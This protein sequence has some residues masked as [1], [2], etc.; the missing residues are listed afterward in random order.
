MN[1]V[2]PQLENVPAGTPFHGN[3]G[4]GVFVGGRLVAVALGF[5][6]LG[7]D[8]LVGGTRVGTGVGVSVGTC[9][10]VAVYTMGVLVASGVG[11]A[12][13]V[14]VGVWVG[15]EVLVAVDVTVK[16]GL[17]VLVGVAVGWLRASSTPLLQTKTPAIRTAITATTATARIITRFFVLLSIS[18]PWLMPGEPT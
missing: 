13:S 15:M 1:D 6:G 16:V 4:A 2:K 17:G 3:C 10:G 7:F 5:V 18:P 8:V 11:V 9:V 14:G 12:V